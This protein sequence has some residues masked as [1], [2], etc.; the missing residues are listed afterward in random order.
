MPINPQVALGIINTV[1]GLFNKKSTTPTLAQRQK[2]MAPFKAGLD[3]QLKRINEYR[4]MGSS[5]YDQMRSQLMNTMLNS[6]DLGDTMA[7][8]VSYGATSNM[9]NQQNM[10]RYAS[11]M[12]SIPIQLGKTWADMQRHSDSEYQNWLAGTQQYTQ[13]EMGAW[14]EAAKARSDNWDDFSGMLSLVGDAL[15]SSWGGGDDEEEEE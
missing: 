3:A 9:Q 4:D 10:D 15:P 13:G 1:G 8:R 14:T 7:S 12:K 11:S 2:Q 6:V 5:F